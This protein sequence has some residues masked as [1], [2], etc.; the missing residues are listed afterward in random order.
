[1]AWGQT[2]DHCFYLIFKS[3]MKRRLADYGMSDVDEIQRLK[4]EVVKLREQA[5]RPGTPQRLHTTIGGET[6][7]QVCLKLQC[8]IFQ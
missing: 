5:K 3:S 1:M 7:A 6:N 2:C 4:D 8:Q